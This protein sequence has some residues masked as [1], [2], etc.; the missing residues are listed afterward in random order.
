MAFMI[1]EY[2]KKA[3]T[4]YERIIHEAFVR[5]FRAMVAT[6]SNYLVLVGRCLMVPVVRG[7]PY[8]PLAPDATSICYI[9]P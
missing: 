4:C 2:E 5:S 3:L 9:I 8:H 7:G 6:G 1:Q